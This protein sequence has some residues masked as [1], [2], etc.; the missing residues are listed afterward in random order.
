MAPEAAAAA[1]AGVTV[2]TAP[3]IAPR[4][5]RWRLEDTGARDGGAGCPAALAERIAASSA[6]TLRASAPVTTWLPRY[7]NAPRD[8]RSA[9][10]RRKWRRAAMDQAAPL[11]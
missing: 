11:A 3:T 6:A 10:P 1:M 9:S 2:T 8:G 5:A 7:R 4:G